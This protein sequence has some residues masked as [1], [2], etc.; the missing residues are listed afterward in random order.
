M[1]GIKCHECRGAFRSNVQSMSVSEWSG[2]SKWIE[3]CSRVWG[4]SLTLLMGLMDSDRVRWSPSAHLHHIGHSN[5]SA[6][7]T[8]YTVQCGMFT[9]VPER[10]SIKRYNLFIVI[11]SKHA[12]LHTHQ[13]VFV[14]IN[15]Y[16]YIF[17]CSLFFIYFFFFCGKVN[18]VYARTIIHNKQK[19]IWDIEIFDDS[20]LKF[21]AIFFVLL[22]GLLVVFI[23][24]G[25]RC[26]IFHWSY[27]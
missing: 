5:I 26:F 20:V 6:R 9:V 2:M 22:V 17:C 1:M 21:I 27:F 3:W 15:I 12:R 25:R 18:W 13:L 8:S 24:I 10:H 4:A 7:R 14:A 11:H 16:I 19:V 23:N